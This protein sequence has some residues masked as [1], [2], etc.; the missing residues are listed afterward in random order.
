MMREHGPDAVMEEDELPDFKSLPSQKDRIEEGGW[1]TLM[2]LD[3][4]RWDVM[5]AISDM[6]VEALRTPSNGSTPGW[7]DS[8]WCQDGWGDV[9]YI[10]ANP[11][12]GMT[13]RMDRY[14]EDIRD[15]VNYIDNSGLGKMPNHSVTTAEQMVMKSVEYDT[16]VV[17]HFIQ[18]HTPFIGK[19][20][21]RISGENPPVLDKG[22]PDS[23]PKGRIARLAWEGKISLDVFRQAYVSNAVYAY[24][25]GLRLAKRM[26]GRSVI[27]A[28]H[29]EGLGPNQWD[30]GGPRFSCNRVVPWLEVK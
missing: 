5:D 18:P 29:G 22:Y 2:V 25:W 7:V 15:Y 1:D 17:S 16:P 4:M 24:E 27:T 21:M 12:A 14:G 6:E 20:S 13:E 10:S 30:H 28:D 26:S 9:N 11:Q 19:V 3:A 8:V 23:A